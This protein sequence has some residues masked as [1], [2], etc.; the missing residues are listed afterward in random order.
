MASHKPLKFDPI[1]EAHRQWVAQ[2][3]GEAALGM[4]LV[5]S[6]MRAQQIYLARVTRALRSFDLTFARFELLALLSFTRTGSLPLNKVGARLQVHPASVTH[7]VDRLEDSGLVRRLPHQTDRRTVLV[8]ILP[9][10]RKVFRR[11][12]RALNEEVFR[13]PGLSSDQAK[14]VVGLI[15]ELRLSEG[16]FEP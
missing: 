12:A 16:D 9:S 15:T 10:G 2:E 11:A 14:I 6:I 3:W 7:V 13:D 5:T 8:S 1:E 4:A